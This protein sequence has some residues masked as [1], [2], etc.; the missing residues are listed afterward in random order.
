[1]NNDAPADRMK[2]AALVLT[3]F[4]AVGSL[5]VALT[6]QMTREQ[7]A[8]NERAAMLR[9]LNVL[10]PEDR[11]DNDLFTDTVQRTD[12]ELLGSPG[13]VTIFRARRDGQPVAAVFRSVAPDG[14]GGP[15]R[16]LVAVGEDGVLEGV[17]VAAHRETPG[18]GDAI[19][20][21][22][23]D[24]ILDFADRSLLDPPPE[25]W[26]VRGDGGAFDELT[27]ATI[28]ARAVVRAVKNTLVYF[29]AHRPSVFA[30]APRSESEAP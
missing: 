26:A 19:E 13:P 30:P 1:M 27:G 12:G 7:I 5:L 23:S 24:W 28:T 9:D 21:G 2:R 3:G 25:Q 22:R 8:A 20:V 29:K 18:L 15:I 10:L 6:W 11:Y 4:A 17:R 14:Y 16:L